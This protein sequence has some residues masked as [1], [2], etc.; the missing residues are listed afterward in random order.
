MLSRDAGRILDAIKLSFVLPDLASRRPLFP[1]TQG[2]DLVLTT[3]RDLPYYQ[4]DWGKTFGLEGNSNADFVRVPKGLL[5]GV[6]AVLPQ[7]SEKGGRN[8]E[9]GWEVMVNLEKRQM[10]RLNAD[11]EFMRYFELRAL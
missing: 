1:N 4:Q 2:K 7:R 10:E 3:W 5:G 6:C 11:A 8:S 9:I